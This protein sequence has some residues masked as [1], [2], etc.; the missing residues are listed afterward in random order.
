[1]SPP[2]EPY[3][4]EILS[5]PDSLETI[6]E[7]PDAEG[8]H[9]QPSHL[10]PLVSLPDA[11]EQHHAQPSHLEPLVSLPDADEQHEQLLADEMFFDLHV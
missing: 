2:V 10:E 3:S 11:D 7:S 1:M 8:Q 6:Q 9:E 5:V 4:H